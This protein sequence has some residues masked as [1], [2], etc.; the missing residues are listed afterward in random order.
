MFKKKNIIKS[1]KLLDDTYDYPQVNDHALT[2]H[3]QIPSIEKKIQKHSG[4]NVQ[5]LGKSAKLQESQAEKRNFLNVN[6]QQGLINI[7][8][9][10]QK[11]DRPDKLMDKYIQDK[12]KQVIPLAFNGTQESLEQQNQ[13]EAEIL[14]EILKN[15]R[16]FLQKKDEDPSFYVGGIFEVN[17]SLE[18]KAQQMAMMED[19]KR[20]QYLK[21]LIEG[22]P[23]RVQQAIIHPDE[24]EEKEE[25][26][27]KEIKDRFYQKGRI[28]KYLQLKKLNEN[29]TAEY[30]DNNLSDDSIKVEKK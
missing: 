14:D 5:V 15:Q 8:Y 4:V 19:L 23:K 20:G 25:R 12:I 9:T 7:N 6:K 22:K 3:E 13:K 30:I 1:D 27:Y 29:N 2:P 11:T 18:E 28:F 10:K 17:L 21:T 16:Q 24:D 26:Q